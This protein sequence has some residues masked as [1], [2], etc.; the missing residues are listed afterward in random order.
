MNS[1]RDAKKILCIRLDAMG[2]VLMTTPAMEALKECVPGRTITL[3]TSKEGRAIA[4]SI[5][6]IDDVIVYGAPWLKA[7]ADRTDPELDF[8][9]LEKIREEKFDAA[10][11]F[12]V[13]SQNPLPTALFCFL[14]GIP[15]RA[16][17]CR[18]N[19]YAL[20]TNWMKEIE[21]E[22]KVRHEVRRH[23]DLV[24]ELGAS[25]ENRPLHLRVEEEALASL[26][27]KLSGLGVSELSQEII[28]IHPGS[29]AA[30]RRYAPKG[31]AEVA[32]GLVKAGK[33]ILFT[34]GP[35]EREL[36]EEIQQYM[37]EDSINLGGEITLKELIALLREAPLLVSNNSGPVHMAAALGTP[38]VD[39]YALTNP[40]HTPWMVGNAVLFKEVSC[41]FCYKS[42]CPEG[43]ND[44]LSGIKPETIMKKGIELARTHREPCYDTQA[45]YPLKEYL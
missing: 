32:D 26:K 31:F 30:S 45:I 38:V 27:M 15:L 41:G 40:Q 22:K 24:M 34:G 19:P 17:Y 8:S 16:A 35:S 4:E 3:L 1:W 23:L 42:V 18:E 14:A 43:H 25:G 29:T 21:P 20:L 44:C 39:L 10:I 7:S 6:F 36:I 28:V 37:H 2:D 33:R 13:Y 11:I 5:P 12:T 9:M